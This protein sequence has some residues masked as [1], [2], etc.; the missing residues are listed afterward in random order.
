MLLRRASR[1]DHWARERMIR[2]MRPLV[3][4]IARGY[5]R[6]AE[7]LRELEQV[8]MIGLIKAV[9]RY[10]GTRDTRFV[11]FAFPTVAGEIR[12]YLR[13]TSWSVHVP[14]ELQELAWRL[15]S[16]ERNLVATLQRRPRDR[17]LAVALGCPADR[18]PSVRLALNAYSAAPIEP[19]NERVR[20][21]DLIGH[22]D[23]GYARCDDRV[24]LDAARRSLPAAEQRAIQLRF[25]HDLTQQEIGE[26][27]DCSQMQVS[28]LLAKALE[29]LRKSLVPSAEAGGPGAA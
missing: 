11:S 26:V 28:R 10:D 22:D 20:P 23:P 12:R 17:E 18:I 9:D 15:P 14:R 29:R 1:G 24:S 13:D 3:R 19:A 6:D 25:E 21:L 16:A 5:A 4:S 27:L 2:S 7:H 8:G